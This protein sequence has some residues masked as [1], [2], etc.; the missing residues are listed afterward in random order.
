MKLLLQKIPFEA[1][2]LLVIAIAAYIL[3]GLVEDYQATQWTVWV[4]Y[5]LLALSLT[6]V[7]GKGGIFSLGQVAFFG[8]GG[9]AYGVVGVNLLNTTGESLSAL[10]TAGLLAALFAAAQGFFMF[11]GNVGDVYIAVITLATT[12][13]LYTFM[14][15]T[16]GRQ[17]AI[18]KAYLGGFNGMTNVPPLTLFNSYPSQRDLLLLT[19]ILAA[20]IAFGV[21]Y[22]LWRPFGKVIAGLRNNELRTQLLGYDA[23]RYKLLLYTLGGGIAGL[24]GGCY[25]AWGQFISPTVFS[26]SQAS[27]VVIYVLVGGR[28]SLTGAFAGA[29][30]VEGLSTTLSKGGTE[31]TPIVLGLVMILIVLVLP[32]GIVPALATLLSRFQLIPRI[33]VQSKRPELKTIPSARVYRKNGGRLDTVD[34]RKTFGGLVA[35][36]SASLEF[37]TPGVYC[38]IGPNGAGKS[39]YFNLLIGRYKPTSG[40]VLFAGKP[41]NRLPIFRRVQQGMGIKLQVVSIF[42]ELSVFENMWLAAY[43][44]SRN[45]LWAKQQAEKLLER[46]GILDYADM[47]AGT[48]SHGQQQWLEIGMVLAQE[49]SVILLDEPTAG[50][51][52]EETARTADLIRELGKHASVIVVEHDMEFVRL[53]DAPVT[54]FHQGQIFAKGRLEELRQNEDLQNIYLGRHH[55]VEVK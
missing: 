41:L 34:L 29:I 7:W 6:L 25:A 8:I 16:S 33:T 22:L 18:G 47:Q 1:K 45:S 3:T 40:Q 30:L 50:M 26:L 13:V 43:A 31:A 27:L 10:V 53:L 54:V 9:Y 49:P 23:R 4:I 37:G 52:R 5:G 17:Y 39:T 14:L 32:T 15:S 48:L 51:T 12:L 20:A 38:L 2:G 21:R 11:Y 42:T 24:A 19:I 55:N 28:A 46:F 35:V 36:A 44:N